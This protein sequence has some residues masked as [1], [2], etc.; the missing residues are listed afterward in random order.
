MTLCQFPFDVCLTR[1]KPVEGGVQ[2]GTTGIANFEIISECGLSPVTQG[3]RLGAGEEQSL[4]DRREDQRTRTRGFAGEQ[5]VEAKAIEG[6]QD[7]FRVAVRLAG[8]GAD[9]FIRGL[10]DLASKGTADEIE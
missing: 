4:S 3:G 2:V 8:Q 7:G 6:E 9:G 5:T 10:E 1:A